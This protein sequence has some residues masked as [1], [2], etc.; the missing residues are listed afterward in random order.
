MCVC[1]C[2]C[3]CVSVCLCLAGYLF[4]CVSHICRFIK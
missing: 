1:V 4:S 2:V 3:V